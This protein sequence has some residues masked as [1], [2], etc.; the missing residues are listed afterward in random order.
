MSFRRSLVLHCGLLCACSQVPAPRAPEVRLPAQYETAASAQ[1]D[2]TQL[3]RWWLLFGDAQLTQLVDQALATGYDLRLARAR[4]EEARAIRDSARTR[5]WPQGNLQASRERRQYS[6][7]GDEQSRAAAAAAGTLGLSET[8]SAAF[9]VSWEID[10]LGRGAAN[11]QAANADF[12]AARFDAEAT[13]STLV[14]DVA[15]ALFNARGLA[16]S[17]EDARASATI[18]ERLY[19]VVSK[20]AELGIAASSEAA[21][22]QVDLL[23][24]Q[25]QVQSLQGELDA[26]RR[27]LL[28]LIGRGEQPVSALEV[29]AEGG[30]P[31]AVPAQVPSDVLTRRPDVREAAA[32]VDSASGNLRLAKLALWPTVNLVPAVG[33]SRQEIPGVPAITLGYWSI[34]GNL[35]VPI[36]DRPRLLAEARAQGARVEQALLTYERAAQTGF[37][38]AEQALFRL[39]ADAAR[40]DNLTLAQDRAQVAYQA[41]VRRYE[42][43]FSD[44]TQALDAERAFRQARTALS[45]ARTNALLHSV[46]A[47]QAL[48]G[49]WESSTSIA[50][51][52]R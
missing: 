13:R 8:G 21:R 6:N 43:G 23:S 34:G 12:A 27:A 17:I 31:P 14:A 33:Y 52:K 26:S 19:T 38:E 48:G 44:L 18:S 42:L 51:A 45:D 9:Q 28:V 41:A 22:A 37:S 32:R 36:L 47:F 25:A 4:I 1:A 10:Y 46:Q 11:R 35:L 2:A 24:A 20:R 29:R 39:K 40:L 50:E 3:D 15:R 16:I 30:R 5:Y 7:L 49:G